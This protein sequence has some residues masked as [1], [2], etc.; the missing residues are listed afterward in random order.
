MHHITYISFVPGFLSTE[1][2]VVPGNMGLKDQTFAMKWVRENI[3][4]F[5]GN[6]DEVTIF[7]NSA[8]ASSVHLQMM[9]PLSKGKSF[10][11][12]QRF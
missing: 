11:K 8:G 9:S 12:I 7:G 4:N 6:A 2:S 1:D 10:T 5:G 3:A